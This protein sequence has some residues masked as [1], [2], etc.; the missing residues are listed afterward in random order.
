MFSKY[1]MYNLFKYIKKIIHKKKDIE[2]YDKQL[3]TIEE[4]IEEDIEE[5]VI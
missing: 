2:F 3:F 1:S 5:Y 4:G